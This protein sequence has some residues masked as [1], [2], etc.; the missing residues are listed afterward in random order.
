MYYQAHM[1]V[2]RGTGTQVQRYKSVTG[3]VGL[4]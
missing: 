3:G 2:V 1:N 4:M